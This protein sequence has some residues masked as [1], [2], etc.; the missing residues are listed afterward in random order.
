MGVLDR[1]RRITG[2]DKEG[3][4][5]TGDRSAELTDLRAR[6]EAVMARRPQERPG[7]VKQH[8]PLQEL[9]TGEE[10]ATEQGAFFLAKEVRQAHELHGDRLVGDLVALN[11]EAAALL[12]KDAALGNCHISEGLFLDTETT[13]LAGGTGTLAFLIGVGRFAG[14]AFVTEQIFI[15]DFSE[16]RAAL[17]YLADLVGTKKFLVS[18]NGKA[19]DVNLLTA[20]FILNRFRNPL[21]GLPHLDLLFPSRRLCGHR[22][23]NSRLVTLEQQLFGLYREN[24]IPGME[25]PARYFSWLRRRDP[26]L[27]ADIFRHNRLDILTL[28]ALAVH[29]AE[30]VVPCARSR[31]ADPRD[32]LAAA[33]LLS[34]RKE[35]ARTTGL[36]QDLTACGHASVRCE[37]QKLLSLTLKRKGDWEQAALLWEAL[38]RENPADPFAPLELAKWYEHRRRNYQAA[39]DLIS[40]MLERSPRLEKD[41]RAALEHRLRRLQSR[42]IPPA[43]V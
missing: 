15:R 7:L 3:S 26:H 16:E 24:D 30:L 21:D 10:I 5:K 31:T 28:A 36:L 22:L 17:A 29:L 4:Q 1:L 27:V 35:Q 41:L 11:M 42:L 33:R 14:D 19:F 39:Y 32:L 25:I 2:E 9:I 43:S 8:P 23:E 37:A 6:I 40:Q 38:L 20:R 12:A 34:A 18:F 13:G